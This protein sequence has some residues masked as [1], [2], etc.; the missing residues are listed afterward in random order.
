MQA[1]LAATLAMGL[2]FLLLTPSHLQKPGFSQLR[3]FIL[4]QI[5]TY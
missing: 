5:V 1:L 3:S 2:A 4:F